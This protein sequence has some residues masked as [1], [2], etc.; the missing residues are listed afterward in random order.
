[1]A[2]E[3]AVHDST[4]RRTRRA[5]RPPPIVVYFHGGGWVLGDELSDDPFC[6]DLCR[7]TGMIVV[8]VGYRHAPE[9][10]VPRRPCRGWLSRQRW[11]VAEHAAELG[12]PERWTDC[13]VAGWSAGGNIAAVT[14][15]AGARSRR[16]GDLP[17]QLLVNPVTDC[18]T[19]TGRRSPRTREGYFL[20]KTR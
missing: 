11:W 13:C 10:P 15:A 4:S 16:A 17:G 6:R 20:T 1:M 3:L 5:P 7:R 14:C 2:V 9:H 8:S 12:G 19:S 18:R